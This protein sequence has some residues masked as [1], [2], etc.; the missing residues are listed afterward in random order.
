MLKL[1]IDIGSRN[2]KVAVFDSATSTILFSSYKSTDINALNTVNELIND[3]YDKL[4]ITCPD[5]NTIG[6]TGY[7]RKLYSY[8]NSVLSEITCH[9]AGCLL[10]FP[11]A[12][13]IIDI[14]GQDS[15][16]ITIGAHRKVEDFVMNDKCAAGTGRFLEMTALKLGCEL[17][18]LSKLAILADSN[19]NLN[20]TC[21]VFAESEIIGMMATAH[22]ANNIA[23]AVHRSVAKRIS[24]QMSALSWSPPVVFTG[25]VALNTDLATC[26]SE[27]L[28]SRLL[29]PP[30]PEITGALGAAILTRIQ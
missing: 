13:T 2:T 26:I 12:N 3:A 14:G 8:A 27:E 25:G 5:I 18:M 23:R 16:I 20:S 9:A 28:N 1:G 17:P 4:N 29:I 24:T 7:G 10:L 6:V 22:S 15:K 21:V 11:T 30:D 19:L